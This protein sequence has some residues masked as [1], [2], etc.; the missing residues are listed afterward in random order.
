LPIAW[1]YLGLGETAEALDWMETALAER[2]PFLAFLMVFPG[3]DS[4]RDQARSRQIVQ[5]LKFPT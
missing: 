1:T 3:Y 5:Q 4:I 2:E